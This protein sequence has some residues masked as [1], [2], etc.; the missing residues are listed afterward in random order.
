MIRAIFFIV[1]TL[2]SGSARAETMPAVGSPAPAFSLADQAGKMHGLDAWKGKWLVLYYYPKDETSGCTA[3]AIAF[4]DAAPQL[5]GLNA[6]VAGVS[7]DDVASHKSFAKNHQINFTLLADTDGATAKRYGALTNLG[8]IK[9]AKR[10]TF[11]IDP[12]GRVAKVYP[13][14]EA[15]RHA[16]EVLADLKLL[17]AG[18]SVH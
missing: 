4:R 11:I 16:S 15:L 5:A 2:L 12:E 10:V 9:F 14:V 7:L 13:D 6:L 18:K 1:V 17:S 8:I 3:E